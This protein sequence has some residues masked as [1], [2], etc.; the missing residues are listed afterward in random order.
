MISE[1]DFSDSKLTR[2][3][4]FSRKANAVKPTS[5]A[6]SAKRPQTHEFHGISGLYAPFGLERRKTRE[7]GCLRV[8]WGTLSVLFPARP[9]FLTAFTFVSR[10]RSYT[11]LPA[12]PL[13]RR[14]QGGGNAK[15]RNPAVPRSI[16]NRSSILSH[17][18]SPM[19]V[20]AFDRLFPHPARSRPS[21]GSELAMRDLMSI[22]FTPTRLAYRQ[23]HRD[24]ATFALLNLFTGWRFVGFLISDRMRPGRRRQCA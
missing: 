4:V 1:Q 23:S 16:R 10:G 7:N 8:C 24:R 9:P 13:L 6:T 15:D 5:A 3:K 12:K 22:Y 17:R 19:C 21:A 18:S 14:A 2:P 20:D 11:L